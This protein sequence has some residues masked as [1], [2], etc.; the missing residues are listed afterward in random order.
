MHLKFHR[1]VAK[2]QR[3]Y[4]IELQRLNDPDRIAVLKSLSQKWAQV[5]SESQSGASRPEPVEINNTELCCDPQPEFQTA[6]AP[7]NFPDGFIPEEHRQGVL[8]ME[9]W[10]TDAAGSTPETFQAIL[11]VTIEYLRLVPQAK[12]WLWR[13][14]KAGVKQNIRQFFP[15]YYQALSI[16]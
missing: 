2:G 8:E 6:T 13:A 4:R 11:D 5:G 3:F 15:D 14:M 1:Q 12:E 7:F 10:L 9:A 16:P